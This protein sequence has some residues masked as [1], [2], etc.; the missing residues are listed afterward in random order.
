MSHPYNTIAIRDMIIECFS[1]EE[2]EEF[3]YEHFRYRKIRGTDQLQGS[4]LQQKALALVCRAEREGWLESVVHALKQARLERFREFEKSIFTE[5]PCNAVE[6]GPGLVE[7]ILIP[8]GHFWIGSTKEDDPETRPEEEPQ[9][10]L[11]LPAYYVGKYPV[12]NAQ[13]YAFVQDTDRLVPDY[14]SNGIFPT[15][16]ENH[17]VVRVSHQDA[18]AFC[19]WLS[20]VERRFYRLPTE[21]EWEKA[22]RGSGD[23][24]R[25]PWGDEWDPERCNTQEAGIGKT[26]PVDMYGKKGASPFGVMDMSGN[27]AEWTCSWY[28]RYPNSLCDNIHFGRTQRVVR[29]GSWINEASWARVSFRG[30]YKPDTRRPY[31]G[32]RVVLEV[33]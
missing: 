6:S 2:L 14:W 9:Q 29:G 7:T 22:A 4:T 17:P 33:F 11:F 1:L 19:R 31:L 30:H 8:D 28:E 10:K 27:V 5:L 21:E 26:T 23:K 16:E 20:M 25:Y 12:T 24:R 32:F 13:Y 18:M 15:G 3:C